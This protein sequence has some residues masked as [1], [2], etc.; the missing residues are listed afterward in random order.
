MSNPPLTV[1]ELF[2]SIQGE[3][4]RTGLPCAFVRLSGCN[5]RCRYCDSRYTWEEH[6][7]KT[8]L[9]EILKWAEAYPEVPVE[10]TG[11]EPLLQEGTYPLMRELAARGRTVLLE[12]NGSLGIGRVPDAVT[13]IL[14][15]KCPDSGMENMIDWANI[16]R[17]AQR[18]KRGCRDEIKFVLSS[19]RDYVWAREVTAE[20]GLAEL[21]TLLLSPADKLMAPSRLAELMLAD[22]SPARLQ[23]Q[24]HRII[25]PA[26]E[27]GV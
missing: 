17:L 26:L 3:S 5:L 11:G 21:A 15:L 25:W 19:E 12:T 18:R 23:L 10:L 1:S 22:R 27:R 20:Y 8:D 24:L 6:G 13:V 4:T 14:D 2:Y 7:R 9:A 16:G